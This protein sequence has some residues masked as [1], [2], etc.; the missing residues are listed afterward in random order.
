MKCLHLEDKLARVLYCI[1]VISFDYA[2]RR[3]VC[4]NV[5]VCYPKRT[6]KPLYHGLVKQ[7]ES[8][9][10][11]FLDPEELL[12]HPLKEMCDIVVDS[13]FGFGFKGPP[14]P[15]FDAILDRLR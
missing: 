1:S 4:E 8:L 2:K 7:L 10:I 13:M 3:A 9:D 5:Q 12:A 6:D 11:S 15:P 14:R